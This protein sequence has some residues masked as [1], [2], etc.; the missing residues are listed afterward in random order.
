[1]GRTPKSVINTS[2]WKKRKEGR[3]EMGCK[4]EIRKKLYYSTPEDEQKQTGT[5]NL[6]ET[7][8]IGKIINTRDGVMSDGVRN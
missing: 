4:A 2:H 7:C 1:M 5:E 6:L 3:K 8:C